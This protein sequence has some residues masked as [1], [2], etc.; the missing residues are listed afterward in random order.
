ML[1]LLVVLWFGVDFDSEYW[2]MVVDRRNKK[3]SQLIRAIIITH[4]KRALA[5]GMKIPSL[6][7]FFVVGHTNVITLE[8]SIVYALDPNS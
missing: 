8:V 6:W 7:A 1:L 3:L 4:T 2:I 5:L